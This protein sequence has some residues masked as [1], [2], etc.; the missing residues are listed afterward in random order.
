VIR[1][2]VLVSLL[3]AGPQDG[4]PA[5]PPGRVITI[6][7]PAGRTVLTRPLELPLDAEEVVIDGH[8]TATLCGGCVVEDPVW[9]RPPE[10]LLRTLPEEAFGRVR[11]LRLPAEQLA[12]WTTG[13]VGPIHF[14]HGTS[15]R[16][17][18]TEVFVGDVALVPARWPNEGWASI[19]RVVDAGSVP[20]TVGEDMPRRD[21]PAEMP[22]GATFLPKDTS[23]LGRWLGPDVWMHGLWNWDWSDE[24]LP[25]ASIDQVAMS[26]TLGAPHTYGVAQRGRFRVTNA[27]GELDT[28]GEMWLDREQRLLYAWLP[29]NSEPAPITISMLDVPIITI[30][31]GPNAPR[32]TIRGVAFRATRGAA[33]VGHGVRDAVIERCDFRNV[34][35]VAIEL[36]GEHCRISRCRFEDIGGVG[37]SL[38]GGDRATLTSAQNTVEDSTFLRC[39]RLQRTYHPAIRLSGVGQRVVHNEIAE[40]P[41]I[42]ITFE[43]NDHLIES[44]H[45][46]HV[47]QETGD[48]GAIYT[49]RDWTS[50]GNVIR[51]N[52]V[53]DIEGTDARF[54]N[55][56]YLDDMASGI[57]VESNI[58]MRCNWGMLIGGGRDNTIRNNAFVACR[59]AISYDARGVGWMAKHIADPSRS[60]LHKRLAA[61]PIDAEPWRTRFPTLGAYL[62]DRFGRPVGGRVI[63]TALMATPL[64]Q[65]E[66]HECVEESGTM[67]VQAPGDAEMDSFLGALIG[68]VRKQAVTIG[69]TTA[70]P[71]GPR[72]E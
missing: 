26:V 67:T 22:H 17:A 36:A 18:P 41:H 64:G 24:Q 7:L 1:S 66:D 37:V 15:M 34:G 31:S 51:G 10:A 43:G 48:S 54:Q 6:D 40:L 13:L 14:G 25:I 53:H 59:K 38:G 63:D 72:P 52:L 45:I 65:I 49:G 70:G 61:L 46:H 60:T 11:V 50:Q 29:Q 30:P 32:V 62:T 19:E 39:G 9:T 58:I 23:R 16:A 35:T 55:A 5:S 2:I 12:R 3:G 69:H 21:G 4:A 71:V 44:N 20:R 28:A 8:G 68:S 47:V 33:I 27:L 42:A 56:V 57:T